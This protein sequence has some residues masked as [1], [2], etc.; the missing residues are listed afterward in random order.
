MAEPVLSLLGKALVTTFGL[1][2]MRPASGTWGSM[3]TV[4][5]AGGL[6]F[7]GVRPEG[8][9]PAMSAAYHGALL[10]VL[11]VF[12]WVCVAFGSA[13]EAHFGKKDPGSVVADET[14]GQAIPLMAL[15]AGATNGLPHLLFALA[16]AFVAFRVC[17]IA[18]L[19]P[20]NGLQRHGGG[21]GILLDD[22]AAGVQA[23]VIVQ[24]VLR[25]M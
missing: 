19:W 7:L 8:S 3:P 6:I 20:A 12:S 24:V 10:A 16:L 5:L 2:H 17:D 14:A 11:V 21:W 9:G 1:G 23:L 22:L 15:P 13:A 25:A 4:A 18:K